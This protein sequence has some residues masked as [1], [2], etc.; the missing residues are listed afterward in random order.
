MKN[1]FFLFSILLSSL[2]IQA[3]IQTPQA[4]PFQKIEQKVGLTDVT[5]EYSRPS[6]KGRTI[7]GGLVPYDEIWR[8][9]ANENT[10][11]TF[12]NDVEIGGQTVNAGTYAIY[13]KPSASSW[14]VYF[15]SDSNNWGNPE[16]WDEGKVAAKVTAPVY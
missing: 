4:S 6:M 1:I 15:Y 12:S 11:I 7:V 14:E 13:T 2:A 5:L 9:G 10:K 3:Q 16:K 8:T